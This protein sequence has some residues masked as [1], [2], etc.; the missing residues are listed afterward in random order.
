MALR[1]P[2]LDMQAPR[3]IVRAVPGSGF[4]FGTLTTG[5]GASRGRDHLDPDDGAGRHRKRSGR[6]RGERGGEFSP[7]SHAARTETGRER[8]FTTTVL[9]VRPRLERPSLPDDPGEVGYVQTRRAGSLV[10]SSSYAPAMEVCSAPT[11]NQ[12]KTVEF[13]ATDVPLPRAA[14]KGVLDVARELHSP[15]SKREWISSYGTSVAVPLDGGGPDREPFAF[16][17]WSNVEKAEG[18]GL[19]RR[20]GGGLR[21]AGL[22]RF[23]IIV[24]ATASAARVPAT[25]GRRIGGAADENE[26]RGLDGRTRAR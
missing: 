1:A 4:R 16:P 25:A 23:R 14:G 24:H 18:G 17:D 5:G 7:D 3:N 9:A 10:P 26:G 22:E 8:V 11:I 2:S 6:S 12:R 21:G 13:S 20:R 19:C 15:A